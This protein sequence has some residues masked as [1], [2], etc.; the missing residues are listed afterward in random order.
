MSSPS[1]RITIHQLEDHGDARE[2]GTDGRRVD[3]D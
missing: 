1:D 2:G 3:T